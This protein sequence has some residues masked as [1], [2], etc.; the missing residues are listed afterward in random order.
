MF[1]FVLGNTCCAVLACGFRG[2][3]EYFQVWI[4]VDWVSLFGL[5]ARVCSAG[6]M[7]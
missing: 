1:R 6:L 5:I 4:L 2:M 3:F 7:R